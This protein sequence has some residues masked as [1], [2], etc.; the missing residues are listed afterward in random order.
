MI[1]LS[2]T[3]ST[4]VTGIRK[5]SFN[6]DL[7]DHHLLNIRSFRFLIHFD[8]RYQTCFSINVSSLIINGNQSN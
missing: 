7:R 3:F 5:H 6:F 1:F 8:R 2:V 4:S